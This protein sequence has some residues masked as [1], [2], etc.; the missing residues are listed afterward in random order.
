MTARIRSSM[1]ALRLALLG[2]DP[3]RSKPFPSYPIL[4]KAEEKAVL[5]VLRRGTLS[6]FPAN[7]LGGEEVRAFEREF[8]AAMGAKHGI[9]VNS[10]TAALH[11]AIAALNVGP[12]DEVIVPC[13]TFTAT[14]T[15]VLHHNAT[16]VF[17]DVDPK[18]FCVTAE[19]IEAAITPRTKAVIPVHLLGNVC[20]MDEIMAMARRR[21][22][23]VIEDNA[24]SPGAAFQGRWAGTFGHA[25]TF[26]FVE[27]KNLVTGE[28]GMVLTDREDVAERCRLVRNH[29]ECYVSGKPRSYVA[30]ILGWNY[31]MTEMEAAVGRVQLKK[32]NQMTERRVANGEYL[33]DR[34]KFPGLTP[35][36][37]ESDVR[38]VYHIYGMLFDETAAGLPR[39]L[40]LRALMAEGIPFS[41]GYPHPLY[42]NPIFQ[43]GTV[44]GS[45]G[46]PF[47]CRPGKKGP[48]YRSLF[49][50]VAEELGRTK[51]LWTSVIRPP[52]TRR[53]MNDVVRAFEKIYENR[54]V[55]LAQCPRKEEQQ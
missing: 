44:Y 43:E 11:V 41:R 27:T 26:S 40:L 38:H 28:G 25:G 35:P 18:T 31:R 7:F 3:V 30:N 46:C 32:F 19:R 33:N 6:G 42:K 51:A 8:A 5:T 47:T 16:P 50:P 4:G 45:D 12:G 21:G 9:A 15:A 29:G 17:I 20:R 54:A 10:G 37:T 49:L 14:A 48:D 55:L 13:Y 34:L 39:D 22:I 23:A 24:Q 53:D 1:G 2:G 36:H 52:A